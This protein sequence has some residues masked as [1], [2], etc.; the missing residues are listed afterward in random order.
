MCA[1]ALSWS[2]IDAIYFGA[3]DVKS[4]AIENGPTLYQTATCHHKPQVFGGFCET[5][6]QNLMTQFFERLR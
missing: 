4:G 3:Y 2:K 1:G 5:E 6:C